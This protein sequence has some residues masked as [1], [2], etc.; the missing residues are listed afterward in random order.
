VAGCRENQPVFAQAG[1][2]DALFCLQ[3]GEIKVTVVSQ[4]G[5]EAVITCNGGQGV[6]L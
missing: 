1:R 2:A 3:G 5:K 4:H 6:T